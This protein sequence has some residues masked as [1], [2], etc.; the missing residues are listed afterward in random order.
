MRRGVVV[1]LN[2]KGAKDF[3]VLADAPPPSQSVP[4]TPQPT[5]TPQIIQP[6]AA[7]TA[8]PVVET[9]QAQTA[10]DTVAQPNNEKLARVYVAKIGLNV[11]LPT[12]L[13]PDAA[14]RLADEKT[15]HL[16]SIQGCADVFFRVSRDSVKNVYETCLKEAAPQG[17]G[18]SID[19]KVLK[20]AW[21]VVSGSSRR[22]GFYIKG[23]KH[24]NEV[25]VMQLEYI[26][27]LCNIPAPVLAEISQKFDGA[28][29][30]VEA[31]AITAPPTPVPETK[32]LFAGTWE[33]TIQVI[34]EGKPV[35][36]ATQHLR[37][38]INEN[39]TEATMGNYTIPIKGWVHRGPRTLVCPNRSN[40]S[41]A[42]YSLTVHDDGNSGTYVND[43]WPAPSINRGTLYKKR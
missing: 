24:G 22:S 41:K 27:A 14:T 37:L 32:S 36:G 1:Y 6:S 29:Q 38:N 3:A 8:S 28:T 39:E 31:P 42:V 21:F 43:N 19:Y 23:V 5:V 33:G 2:R 18:K 30:V 7:P 4:V 17:S 10:P 15:D 16:N 20:P 34:V 26:G 11:L 12:A 25:A 40:K 9:P 13:F 35:S